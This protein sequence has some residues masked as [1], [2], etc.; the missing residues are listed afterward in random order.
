MMASTWSVAVRRFPDMTVDTPRLRVRPVRAADADQIASIF[1][2]RQTRRWLPD[3]DEHDLLDGPLGHDYL[4]GS[5][6]PGRDSSGARDGY[7]WCTELAVL[8]RD[9][10]E[11]DHYGIVRRADQAVIGCLWVRRTDWAVGSTEVMIAVDGGHRGF[12]VAGEALDALAIALLLE[13]GLHRVEVRIPPANLPA[14]RVADKAGFTYEGLLR[15]AGHVHGERVD[16][17]LWSLVAADL[18]S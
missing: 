12:G 3:P 1:A 7:A 13:Q 17:Q 4:D 11:G 16:L 8:R 10:G 15:N 6:Q 5:A 18:R 14:R 2:D 9:S